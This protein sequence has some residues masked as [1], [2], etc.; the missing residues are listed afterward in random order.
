MIF[1]MRLRSFKLLA[2]STRPASVSIPPQYLRFYGLSLLLSPFVMLSEIFL[3]SP[4]RPTGSSD[5]ILYN[6]GT[7][8]EQRFLLQVNLNAATPNL[9]LAVDASTATYKLA[10]A[11]LL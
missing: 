11:T 4:F 7:G 10:D 1:R 6:I 9:W 3:S 5:A 8:I 2:T